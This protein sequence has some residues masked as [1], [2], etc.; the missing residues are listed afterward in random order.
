[1]NPPLKIGS[2]PIQL[3]RA[4]SSTPSVRTSSWIKEIYQFATPAPPARNTTPHTA[5]PPQRHLPN[6][7][8]PLQ[9]CLQLYL[10][11]PFTPR[12]RDPP[13]SRSRYYVRQE[14]AQVED[15]PCPNPS[16]N[17]YPAPAHGR[18]KS[19][20]RSKRRSESA[21]IKYCTPTGKRP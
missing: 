19:R 3:T 8:I 14:G 15:L 11:S 5:F 10:E 12:T 6:T 2:V 4:T 20:K 16:D 7:H 21:D 9:I 13:T 18:K 17:L 1:M